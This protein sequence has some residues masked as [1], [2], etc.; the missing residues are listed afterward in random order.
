MNKQII[1]IS[2]EKS[3]RKS[4]YFIIILYFIEYNS[5]KIPILLVV[6]NGLIV[7]TLRTIKPY[8]NK[9][10]LLTKKVSTVIQYLETRPL[11]LHLHFHYIFSIGV[12]SAKIIV[13][14]K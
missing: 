7:Q 11:M 12:L 13:N 4:I 10:I 2:R 1:W 8:N 3:K 5:S 6:I 14:N 9:K